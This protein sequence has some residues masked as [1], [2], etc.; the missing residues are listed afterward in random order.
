MAVGSALVNGKRK[1][2]AGARLCKKDSL[3][4]FALVVLEIINKI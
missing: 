2:E 1:R 4:D 3:S